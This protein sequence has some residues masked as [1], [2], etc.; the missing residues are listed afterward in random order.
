MAELL[1]RE[2]IAQMLG[3]QQATFRKCIETRD[4]FPKPVL[5][6]SRVIVRW[7]AKDIQRWVSRQKQLAQ[8]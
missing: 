8:A 6:L 1:D 2:T 5:K 3:V 7:D 4:D